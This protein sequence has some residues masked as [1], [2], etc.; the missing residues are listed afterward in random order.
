MG[1]C[2][3]FLNTWYLVGGLETWFDA[4]GRVYIYMQV[5]VAGTACSASWRFLSQ[6]RRFPNL[7]NLEKLGFGEEET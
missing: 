7:H 3:V 5:F 2:L 1:L 6:E 4:K